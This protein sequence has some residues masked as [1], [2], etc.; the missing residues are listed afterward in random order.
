MERKEQ[1]LGN[2][3]AKCCLSPTQDGSPDHL[4]RGLAAEDVGPEGDGRQLG[5]AAGAVDGVPGCLA[6][7]HVPGLV[8]RAR[9]TGRAVD[10]PL[11][12]SDIAATVRAALAARRHGTHQRGALELPGDGLDRFDLPLAEESVIVS[13]PPI[14]V[15]RHASFYR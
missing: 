8:D 12:I 14:E 7:Q 4:T 2:L 13:T 10:M 15:F 6:D 11:Q 5:V 1:H 3:A 9:E